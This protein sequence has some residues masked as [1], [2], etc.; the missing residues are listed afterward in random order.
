MHLRFLSGLTHLVSTYYALAV[1]IPGT[2]S[3]LS[4]PQW[5]INESITLLPGYSSPVCHDDTFT[6]DFVL[7]VTYENVSIGCQ[8]RPS[9]VIN[10]S[11]P[12]PAV[13]LP[14]GVSSWI[15][16]YNEMDEYNF[17]MHWHGLAQR[18]AIFSDGSVVSQWPI[19][20]HHFFDYEVHP[21][22][23][24]AG[25]YF[26][27]SHVGFQ[28][29]TA[30]GPLIVEDSGE[31][32]YPYDEERI[33]AFTDYFNKTD[34]TIEEGLIGKPFKWSGETNAV[35]INGVG[36]SVDESAGQEECKLPVIDVKPD[37]TYR[38]RFI[39]ALA[40]SMVQFTI[41]DHDKFTIIGADGQY[42]LPHEVGFMQ[43]T[44][45]QRFDVIF[46]TKAE[47]ELGDQ[48]DFLIQF[49]T[50]GRPA[51]YRGYGVLRYSDAAPSITQAPTT[52]P[53]TLGDATYAWLEYAL[54]PLQPN[55]FP[56]ADEVTRRITIYNRQVPTQSIIWQL[57]VSQWN[58]STQNVVNPGGTPYLIEI[59]EKVQAAIPSYEA[60]LN[61]GG[62]DPES[63]T[64]PAK[65]GEVLEIIWYNTGSLV[66][67]GVDFHPLHAHGGHYYDIGSGN[68]S[69][70]PVANEKKLQNYKP[71]LRDTTNLH[72]Y[73]TKTDKGRTL[74][75]RGWR[76]RV[77]DAGVW[78]VHC[79][80]LQHMVMGMQSVW[81][82]GDADQIRSVPQRYIEGYLT[83]GGSAYGNSSFA[84]SYPHRIWN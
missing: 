48:K 1:A 3:G 44:S 57:N 81:V 7:V 72:I 56:T 28:A 46:R 14:A 83:F 32:P 9:V 62:W 71:V 29:V 23:G 33:I 45:G 79:H 35:L 74:G 66:H 80:Q 76:L 67:G 30:A 77:E 13:R 17:T 4:K 8:S 75:W 15:R 50:K 65:V 51:V 12:G 38:L 59:Y 39:G 73:T 42:T 10:G 58:E 2:P 22:P 49:E 25:T 53:L 69:Y 63:Y 78:M 6:P 20:P 37:T 36:V 82:M 24:D 55:N 61:N 5:G 70:N 27:H 47:A 16:V 18:A 31:P 43:V 84:P 21:E 11:T 19:A 41:V 60:A 40:L 68:D 52:P 34:T 64:W 54:E 26:Y